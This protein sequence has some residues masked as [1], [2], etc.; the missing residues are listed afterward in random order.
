[1][2]TLA[3]AQAQAQV[4]LARVGIATPDLDA[5]W[6]LEAATG[7]SR[8]TLV[9]QAQQELSPEQLAIYHSLIERR[10]AHEPV[11]RILG[12]REFWGLPF[13]LS[14]ATLEPR[15]DSETLIEAALDCGLAPRRILDLGTGT[16]CLLA[17][18]LTEYPQAT[19]VA[20]DC[21][22][23]ALAT[24]QENFSALGL[25][26]RVQC[27]QSNWWEKVEGLFDLVISNPP[28][29]ARH[30][31]EQV[32]PEVRQFDPL[33][34]LVS[35]ADGLEAYR[36]ILAGLSGHL[37]PGGVAVLEL[38]LGQGAGVSALAKAQ[39]LTV[40]SIKNDLGGVPRAL[41]VVKS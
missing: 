36:A 30:E 3:Q 6:L 24:A 18:L 2:S 1:V 23:A 39:N 37:A 41:V 31:L 5:R 35:G 9:M 19:G 38:G 14:P 7:L 25:A 26:D 21:S 8:T 34:A 20:V 40:K 28:Y 13:K 32:Q 16:G 22:A 27:L 11:A 10:A 4:Y 29:L 33:T 15:P 12:Q 17:A